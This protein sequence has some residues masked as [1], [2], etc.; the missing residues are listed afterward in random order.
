[1]SHDLLIANGSTLTKFGLGRAVVSNM[2]ISSHI[3][4]VIDDG[5]PR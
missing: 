5:C 1:M 4:G 3:I 2:M